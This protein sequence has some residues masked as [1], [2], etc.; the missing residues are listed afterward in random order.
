MDNCP[1]SKMQ[2]LLRVLGETDNEFRLI[3]IHNELTIDEERVDGVL[4]TL[5]AEDSSEIVN[6]MLTFQS[7]I[8]EKI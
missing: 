6:K 4:L 8:A 2:E 3:T 1:N 7:E 5:T